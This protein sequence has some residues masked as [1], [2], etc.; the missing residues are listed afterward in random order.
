ME[1]EFD[2]EIDA[3]LRRGGV[4]VGNSPA[5]GH[6][7]ADEMAAFAENAMPQRARALHL[8]HIANCDRCRK[9]LSNLIAVNVQAEPEGGAAVVPALVPVTDAVPWYRK[10]FLFPNLAYVMGGLV[11]LFGGLIGISVFRSSTGGDAITQVTENE[12][13]SGMSPPAE[14]QFQASSNIANTTAN[15]VANANSAP[16]V[17][18]SAANAASNAAVGA[19]SNP[20]RSIASGETKTSTS[21]VTAA[22]APAATPM[23]PAAAPP[24]PSI[25]DEAAKD[26]EFAKRDEKARVVAEE[27][28]K[29]KEVALAQRKAENVTLDG[30]AVQN[31]PRTQAGGVAKAAPGPTRDM[32]QSFPNRADNTN[33]LR[34]RR[35]GGR[36]F[37]FRNG[38]WYD[39]EYHGQET[40]NVRRG[41]DEYRKLDSV[42]R[43]IAEKLSG[44]VVVVSSGKAYRIQ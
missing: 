32:Q 18:G 16:F 4:A 14:P 29:K 40:T 1:L 30:R 28:E 3:L 35:V 21:D 41:T 23:Q 22:E 10:L 34:S 39:T 44:V 5:D 25:A 27:S 6:L 36:D 13:A 12:S 11:I 7:D 2:K 20:D 17:P 8:A 42:T 9:I 33:E 26:R 24:P 31:L 15:T 19:V 38:V 37:Q 43:S